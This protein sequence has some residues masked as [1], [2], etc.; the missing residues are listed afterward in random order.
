MK[1]IFTF[2]FHFDTSIPI[3]PPRKKRGNT[4]PGSPKMAKKDSD[5]EQAQTPAKD[6]NKNPENIPS[7]TKPKKPERPPLPPCASALHGK[8]AGTPRGKASLALKKPRPPV[9][10]KPK[11]VLERYGHSP[12]TVANGVACGHGNENGLIASETDSLCSEDAKDV[13]S[14]TNPI[15]ASSGEE[16]FG[17]NT[18]S[19][20]SE[21]MDFGESDC[22]KVVSGT[23]NS[24]DLEIERTD[25]CVDIKKPQEG[26]AIK[27][28][29]EN[30]CVENA[31]RMDL[32][33]N[34][35]DESACDIKE[36]DKMADSQE[37]V[38]D[39]KSTDRTGIEELEI[40][41][42]TK[43]ESYREDVE[44]HEGF[45][46]EKEA[47]ET[48]D[49]ECATTVV[50]DTIASVTTVEIS[51]CN[52]DELE[53]N[54]E[55]IFDDEIKNSPI[56]TISSEDRDIENVDLESSGIMGEVTTALVE[57]KEGIVAD[58]NVKLA[59]VVPEN[60]N[61]AQERDIIPG[62]ENSDLTLSETP[63]NSTEEVYVNKELLDKKESI[64][65]DQ[66]EKGK[67][68]E[69]EKTKEQ[70][71]NDTEV[72][73][74]DGTSEEDIVAD[75]VTNGKDTELEKATE[76]EFA[77][78]EAIPR[79]E[80]QD[81]EFES[82][83]LGQQ[84][85]EG[86]RFELAEESTEECRADVGAISGPE[87]FISGGDK[88]FTAAVTEGET[89]MGDMAGI[90][91]PSDGQEI[92]T[93]AEVKM[94]DATEQDAEKN[95]ITNAKLPST[96]QEDLAGTKMEVC[97]AGEEDTK[98]NTM[99]EVEFGQEDKAGSGREILVA[100]EEDTERNTIVDVD[101]SSCEQENVAR[102][103]EE[104][105]VATEKDVVKITVADIE[106]PS[107]PKIT[108]EETKSPVVTQEREVTELIIAEKDVKDSDEEGVVVN[109]GSVQEATE[110]ESSCQEGKPEDTARLGISDG[111]VVEFGTSLVSPQ[112]EH[113][114]VEITESP[115]ADEQ[116]VDQEADSEL[117][118]EEQQSGEPTR[119]SRPNRTIKLQK[120]VYEEVK[121]ISVESQQKIQDELYEVP[122]AWSP[123]E[124]QGKSCFA[125]EA[126]YDEP[127]HQADDEDLV[128][129]DVPSSVITPV[130]KS[131][132]G[133]AIA[134]AEYSVPSALVSEGSQNVHV[135]PVSD[136]DVPKTTAIEP[137]E[138]DVGQE[139]Y[140]VP[141]PVCNV[142]VPS[143][144]TVPAELIYSAPRDDSN[145][146]STP[147]GQQMAS[148]MSDVLPASSPAKKRPAPPKPPR[149][150]SLRS[151]VRPVVK[152]VEK[153]KE[154]EVLDSSRVSEGPTPLPT[155]TSPKPKPRSS[156]PSG[157]VPRRGMQEKAKAP[158]EG[159]PVARP[160]SHAMGSVVKPAPRKPSV[161]EEK[162]AAEEE[163]PDE[164]T[165]T[166]DRRKN[167]PPR[168]PPPSADKRGSLLAPF[169]IS[170]SAQESHSSSGY[171]MPGS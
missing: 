89:E 71:T 39:T 48:C 140:D 65:V 27:H 85:S 108:R 123:S 147:Q 165:P 122:R 34:Q 23:E 74:R 79:E 88:E 46:S 129:Y 67:E 106:L 40:N 160:R 75:V 162:H 87:V 128:A 20:D 36:E 56:A 25:V 148:V 153:E 107:H 130:S 3:A 120:H 112:E 12:K 55:L 33:D 155:K 104:A 84:K 163:S 5:P 60:V 93:G 22:E 77:P 17:L 158:S 24:T 53:G 124:S 57:D 161:L 157:A 142:D 8:R 152:I 26:A 139:L 41:S 78:V 15:P 73:P 97:V 133:A 134:E 51:E 43:D 72:E 116:A 38:R 135:V 9:P 16:E 126:N 62:T 2:I 1:S 109:E 11:Y 81:V 164:G 32:L 141:S 59:D 115:A 18:V 83:L 168:P 101:P 144:A 19:A 143:E 159:S 117:L 110:D 64:G 69:E 119:P 136:Y 35:K 68:G 167:P 170:A 146:Y 21:A 98:E 14:K 66:L 114:V 99:T 10:P 31:D 42:K 80:S 154:N 13:S 90:G 7:A 166:T 45:S 121:P 111:V 138:S 96:G 28:S 4:Y 169:E 37:Q 49:T 91:L 149:T 70:D 61:N 94:F 47:A 137:S 29:S 105:F 82:E 44:S 171:S 95:E 6:S 63:V 76:V 145:G 132:I 127:K 150:S 102:V 151:N 156:S 86:G 52:V 92:I 30:T 103:E 58:D 125:D 50:G 113:E 54:S 100:T 118:E 131:Q